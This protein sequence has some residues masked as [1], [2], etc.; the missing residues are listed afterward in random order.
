MKRNRVLEAMGFRFIAN[1]K[2]KEI[3]RVATM[4]PKRCGL[5]WANGRNVGYCTL[6][7]ALMLMRWFGYDGCAMCNGR[8]NWK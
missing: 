1:R 2:T 6:L 5:L 8:W 4:H 3:H 7:W